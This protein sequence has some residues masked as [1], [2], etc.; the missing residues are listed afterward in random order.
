MGSPECTL[1]TAPLCARTIPGANASAR[2]RSGQVETVFNP[3]RCENA[4]RQAGA[5]GSCRS[6]RAV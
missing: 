3:S 4:G 1:R 6:D 5:T 2:Q